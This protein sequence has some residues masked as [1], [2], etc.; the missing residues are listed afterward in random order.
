M[1]ILNQLLWNKIGPFLGT[2]VGIFGKS[3]PAKDIVYFDAAEP[4]TGFRMF[5][6]TGKLVLEEVYGQASVASN[7]VSLESVESG[8][9][10]YVLQQE[11]SQ[12]TGKLVIQR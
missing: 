11:G 8:V 6:L 12:S 10:F 2:G 7:S 5:D 4:V 9:Y 3:V 1:F